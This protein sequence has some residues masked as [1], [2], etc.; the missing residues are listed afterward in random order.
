MHK[1]VSVVER[2]FDVWRGPAGT[3]GNPCP[4]ELTVMMALLAA[5]SRIAPNKAREEPA[6]LWWALRIAR[7][8]QRY[9]NLIKLSYTPFVLF[10]YNYY[11]NIILPPYKQLLLSAALI[12]QCSEVQTPRVL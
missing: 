12:W 6:M 10:E 7:S 1:P 3:C 9:L 2:E 4:Q 11:R 8:T 5:A